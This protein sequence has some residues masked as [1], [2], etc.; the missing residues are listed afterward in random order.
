VSTE[1]HLRMHRDHRFWDSEVDFWRDD[2]RAWQRELTEAWSQLKELEAALQRHEEVLREHAASLRLDQEQTSAHEH[3][4]AEYE[5]GGTGPD[6]PAMAV[7]HEDEADR[8]A[9]QR[10]RHEQLKRQHHS[11]LARWRALIESLTS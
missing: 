2:L 3:A 7:G 11:F 1:A 10:E 9:E 6:L 4:L 8:H 5:R